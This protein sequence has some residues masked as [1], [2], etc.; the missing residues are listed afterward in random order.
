M[1]LTLRIA[2]VVYAIFLFILITYLLKRGRIT[3]KHSIVWYVFTIV[4]SLVGIVPQFLELFS[5]LLG[6]EVLSN[7]VI[8]IL[9]VLITIMC[10]VLNVMIAGQRK[11][12]TLLIQEISI[13][14][15][16]IEEKRK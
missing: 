4:V 11:K 9:I 3:E 14:K 12:T 16:E 10:L 7:F 15:K 8:G 6:F 13:L 1:Q 5:K 2:L